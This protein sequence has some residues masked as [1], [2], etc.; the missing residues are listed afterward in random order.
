MQ[1]KVGVSLILFLF[2]ALM[3][4]LFV[5]LLLTR[6]PGP[7]G[8]L[9]TDYSFL[10]LWGCYLLLAVGAFFAY[11]KLK[12]YAGQHETTAEPTTDAEH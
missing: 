2:P 4:P 1:A 6:L 9:F 10:W 5:L 12:R 7:I 8:A 3:V 11:R